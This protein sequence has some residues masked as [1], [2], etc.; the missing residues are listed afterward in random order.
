MITIRKQSAI[1]EVQA[2]SKAQVSAFVG[3]LVDYGV[4]VFLTEV[5]GVHYLYSIIIGGVVGA[6]VNYAINRKWSFK[7]TGVI[8]KEIIKFGL[9]A[10]GS[11]LLKCGGTY[12]LTEYLGLDYKL[13]RLIIDAIV[14][15]GFNYTLHR[16]WVF[17]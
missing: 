4:M 9:V 14:S 16:L 11:I 6:F 13:S 2:F 5:F 1:Q 3:G 10:L 15:L 17:K 12:L 8:H 7:S